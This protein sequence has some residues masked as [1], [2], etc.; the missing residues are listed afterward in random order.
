TPK[1]TV[2]LASVRRL[3]TAAG[4][5][6]SGINITLAPAD[7]GNVSALPSPYAKKS[8][9]AEN[10]TSRSVSAN[11]CSP[12]VCAVQYRLPCECTVPFGRPV[13]PDEYN[14][15]AIESGPV[16]AQLSRGVADSHQAAKSTA[17][18]SSAAVG[19]DTITWRTSCTARC[20]AW[21]NVGNSA[22]ETMSAC[23]REC[24][25]M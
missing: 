17:P 23:A 3:N 4:V 11:T 16:R 12:Y 8:L 1:N 18:L 9:A 2:G 20:I 21:R 25:S 7:N 14:Q 13:E 6:R 15:N 24:S 5:G 19:R 22:P 10:T